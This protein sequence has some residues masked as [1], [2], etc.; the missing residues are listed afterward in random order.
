MQGI[1]QG[2]AHAAQGGTV[3]HDAGA[4]DHAV[5]EV[6]DVGAPLGVA[7]GDAAVKQAF[8][9]EDGEAG[10]HVVV[11]LAAAA[12]GVGGV[13]GVL[14]QYPAQQVVFVVEVVIEGLTGQT[15]RGGDILHVDAVQGVVLQQFDQSLFDEDLGVFA[16][17][18]QPP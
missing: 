14:L 12:E 2:R 8:F 1:P 6:G 13:V 16:N 3:L 17:H 5:F 10:G 4:V 11:H 18:M 15:G 9:L 7:G